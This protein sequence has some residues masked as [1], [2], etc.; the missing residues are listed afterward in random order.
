MP[1]VVYLDTYVAGL[2][3]FKIWKISEV[4]YWVLIAYSEWHNKSHVHCI[5]YKIFSIRFI[6]F[7][8]HKM[9]I[10]KKF[11]LPKRRVENTIIF[12]K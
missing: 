3:L 10:T 8:L 5:A 4:I 1:I 11:Y 6:L 2:F 7:L 9:C 12:I